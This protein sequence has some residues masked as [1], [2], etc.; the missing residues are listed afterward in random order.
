MTKSNDPQKIRNPKMEAQEYLQ[1]NLKDPDPSD[2]TAYVLEPSPPAQNTEPF[3]ADMP[4]EITTDPEKAVTP[5][6]EGKYSWN[7]FPELAEF[8]RERWL[9][10]WQ[11]LPPLPADWIPKMQDAHRLAFSLISETRKQANGKF[12]LRWVLGGFGTPY[13][14]NDC[15][16]GMKYGMLTM[17][18][19][20]KIKTAPIT[21]IKDASEFFGVA[22]TGDQREHDSP[23]L[24]DLE[25]PLIADEETCSFLNGWYGFATS[26]MSEVRLLN[27]TFTPV[28]M[29]PG[30]FDVAVDLPLPDKETSFGASPGDENNPDPYLYV[31]TLGEVDKSNPYWNAESYTGAVLRLPELAKESDQRQAALNFYRQGVEA[32]SS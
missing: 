13:F 32:F 23:E 29:W 6:S 14:G 11:K 3:F 20:G 26:V 27:P 17:E 10:H 21:T 31:A 30:H 7:D 4:T 12:G 9:G 5:T 1:S 25:R 28:Q 15:Q 2:L 18:E 8:A 22:P 24:G 19:A 16:A